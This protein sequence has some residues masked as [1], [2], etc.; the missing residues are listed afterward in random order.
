MEKPTKRKAFN[1]LRSYFDV[2]NELQNDTD[3]FNFLMAIIN[4]QFLDEDPENL[5]F[6]VNLCYSSQKHSVESSVKGWKRVSNTDMEGNPITDTM[7]NPPTNPPTNPIQVEEKEEVKGK[8]KEEVKVKENN[9]ETIANILKS[10]EN[11][12]WLEVIAMQ[13][14]KDEEWVKVKIDEFLIFLRTQIKVH[15]N[16]SEFVSHFTNWLPKKIEGIKIES[17]KNKTFYNSPIL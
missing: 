12:S 6:I 14:K 13:N 16:K 15:K 5:S 2:V 3:K 8:V 7:T 17:I 10:S 4:K 11:N 9:N 1:F